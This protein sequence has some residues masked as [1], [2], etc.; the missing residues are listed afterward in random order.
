MPLSPLQRKAAFA[1]AAILNRKTQTAAAKEDLGVSLPH[2][3]G[4]MSGERVGSDRLEQ[5]FA[6]YIGLPVNRVWPPKKKKV[7]AA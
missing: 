1:S 4:V 3:L 5:R 2:L 6:E 7:G